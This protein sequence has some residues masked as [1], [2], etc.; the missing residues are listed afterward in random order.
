MAAATAAL[1]APLGPGPLPAAFLCLLGALTF[2]APAWLLSIL[3]YKAHISGPWDE[4]VPC[5][6]RELRL[7]LPHPLPS[8][9][10]LVQQPGAGGQGGGGVEGGGGGGETQGGATEGA[11]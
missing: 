8:L 4:A 6:P 9:S 11:T 1:L 5:I 10:D 3:K 2:G 7:P